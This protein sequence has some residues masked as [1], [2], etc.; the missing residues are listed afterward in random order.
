M[1]GG[2]KASGLNPEIINNS[3]KDIGSN[4][5]PIPGSGNPKH[6]AAE[7]RLDVMEQQV[8]VNNLNGGGKLKGGSGNKVSITMPCPKAVGASP[9]QQ[10]STCDLAATAANVKI[11]TELF[12]QVGGKRK[13]TRKRKVERRKKNKS[14]KSKRK[15]S[16]KQKKSRKKS[17]K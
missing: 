9:A 13:K 15:K 7:Q 14:K 8:A 6:A 11:Q 1:R 10:A 16:R 4:F 17:K 5:V 12:N 3:L 2:S